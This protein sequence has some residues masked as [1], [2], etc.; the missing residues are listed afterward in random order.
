MATFT[1]QYNLKKPAETD[2]YNIEDFNNN[3]DI[4]ETALK[5]HEQAINEAGAEPP[6]YTT[7]TISATKWNA[8]N[9][10][11]SFEVDYPYSQY[12]IEIQP[13]N[14]MIEAQIEAWSAAMIA[15]NATSNVVKALGEVPLIDLPIIIK[16][17][18]K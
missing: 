16:A 4:I 12:D 6:I 9:K 11:Y 3:M 2:F 1:E 15:G 7:A 17:V 5:D 10:T 13:N 8:I 14:T 18:K